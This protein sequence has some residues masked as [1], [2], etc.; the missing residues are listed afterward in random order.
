MLV[1]HF[2]LYRKDL[3]SIV[4]I[5]RKKDVIKDLFIMPLINMELKILK[6]RN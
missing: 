5:L 6:S 1:K 2:P 3:K 4:K